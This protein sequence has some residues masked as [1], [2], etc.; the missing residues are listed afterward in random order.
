MLFECYENREMK[1]N[2]ASLGLRAKFMNNLKK[3]TKI[4]GKKSYAKKRGHAGSTS[5]MNK[6][7]KV[8]KETTD[9]PGGK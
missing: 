8:N 9:N 4:T 1:E 5:I 7:A 6:K 2:K 3:S